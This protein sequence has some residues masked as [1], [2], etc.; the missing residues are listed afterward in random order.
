MSNNLPPN[1]SL[2]K[3]GDVCEILD[4]KRS[5]INSNERDKRISGKPIESLFPYYGATGQVGYID[6]YL[7]EG[8]F[9]LLGEDGAPFLEKHKPKAY[10]VNGKIWVNNHAHILLSKNHNKFLCYYLNFLDYH[11]FVT[12]T[13]RLKLNQSSMRQ[14]PIINPP[15]P[16]QKKIVEKI[17]ELFSGLDSGV[18][19]LKK[20]KE[21]IRLY[22]QS[23]LSAAF[24]GRLVKDE[25]RETK[26]EFETHLNGVQG[27]TEQELLE[28]LPYKQVVPKAAEPKV[29]YGK[30]L[31]EGWKWVKLGVVTQLNPK[32]PFEEIDENI[33]VSF[34]PMRQVEELTGKFDLSM[35][36]KYSEVKKGF[37]PFTNGDVIFAKIT[38]CMENGKIAV[39]NKLKNQV[40]FGS[41]EF[42]VFRVK[43]DLV[44]QYLFYFLIQDTFR[45]KAQH[46]MTGAVGQKRVPKRF[47]E[48]SEI[49]L[50]PKDQQH[51][52][53]SEI[54]KR[55]SEA[56]NLEKAIDESLTKSETL[57]QSI[58]KQAFS[59]KLIMNN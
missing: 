24:S 5:P 31:P 11:P 40:G 20:A 4:N 13:T 30:D 51:Q 17:E 52:I 3:L 9:V 47:L 6:D 8:E 15:L 25:K 28:H 49:P 34:L 42:H 36:K 58:L 23:V 50:P 57:R 54:E 39:V 32:L 46:N 53:V 12:G 59:G 38:P 37:T 56:D 19:S 35:E 26:E 10:I 21:Q 7:L 14:I 48:E 18:A 1:W 41:T 43:A 29:G 2:V 22:R 44:N 27:V 16:E 33:I 45:A 55:F